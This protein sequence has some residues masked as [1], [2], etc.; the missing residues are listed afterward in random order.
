MDNNVKEQ[1]AA[2]YPLERELSRLLNRFSQENAS[3]TPDLA[4]KKRRTRELLVQSFKDQEYHYQEGL[5]I[6]ADEL[7]EDSTFA[8]KKTI[9]SLLRRMI[10]MGVA[11]GGVWTFNVRALRHILAMRGS[12]YAEEEIFFVASKIAAMMLDGQP[13]LYGD[14]EQD[15]RGF[16]A[17]KYVKV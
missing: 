7:S 6:W 13:R 10:G 5:D 3:D 1:V 12:P 11:T 16:W 8:N 9:T 2:E 15:E 17:P 4:E 14:F